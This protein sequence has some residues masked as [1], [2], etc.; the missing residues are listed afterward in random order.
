MNNVPII[1][2]VKG[3]L[4]KGL[5]PFSMP[6]H[7]MGRAFN[8]EVKRILL[9]GDLTEVEGLDNLHNPEGIIKDAQDKLTKLYNSKQSYFLVNGSTCGNLIMIFATLNEGDKVL[10][11]RNC[12]RSIMNAIILRKLKP[13]FI[14]NKYN[15]KLKAPIGVD[16]EHLDEVLSVESNIKGI[17]LTY[18]NYY[19]IGLGIQ[20]I[21]ELCR[22]KDIKVL[23]DSAHGA[24]YGFNKELPKSPQELGADIVVMSAHKT[25]PSLTQTSY[26]HVNNLEYIDKVEFYKG[27]FMSTSPSY[28]MM[29]SL[30]YARNY[31]ENYGDND[32]KNLIRVIR[33][34]NEKIK[35]ITYLNIVDKKFLCENCDEDKSRMCGRCNLQYDLSRI[36]INLKN[37]Y[38]GNKLLEYLIENNVQCEMSDNKNIVLIPSPFNTKE[39][40]EILYKA[41]LNCNSEIIKSQE[42]NFYDVDIPKRRFMPY[43]IIQKESEEVSFKSSLGRVAFENIVPYPPG[44]PMLVSGEIIEEKHIKHI[45]SYINEKI[46]VM[47]VNNH[48]IKVVKSN[49][50]V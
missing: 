47:G 29:M 7:K 18:P 48:Y 17:I 37:G 42:Q 49:D 38:N 39:D 6:G 14:K 21:I 34:F 50:K 23:I 9:E 36:V 20:N 13:I 25:L 10:V 22:R 15:K 2:G 16:L 32:Y 8:E 5:V 30:D 44:V 4:K 33:N 24:H 19:G 28:M 11:E 12:H 31:L 3:Y 46:T 45:E 27:I 26:L 43:E 40:F 35:N 1:N 41:L